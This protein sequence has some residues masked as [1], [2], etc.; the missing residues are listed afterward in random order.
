LYLQRLVPVVAM[1]VVMVVMVD[2]SSQHAH[3]FVVVLPT[4]GWWFVDACLVICREVSKMDREISRLFFPHL[5]LE[6]G[7]INYVFVL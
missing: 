5:T 3:F 2:P 7:L 1:V 6:F 4:P